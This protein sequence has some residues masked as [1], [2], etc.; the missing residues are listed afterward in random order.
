[1]DAPARHLCLVV[2]K[3]FVLDAL[4][5]ECTK[6]S[7]SALLFEYLQQVLGLPISTALGVYHL[8]HDLTQHVKVASVSSVAAVDMEAESK[9]CT[10]KCLFCHPWKTFLCGDVINEVRRAVLKKKGELP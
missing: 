6:G 3:Q 9:K 2:P 10:T 1:M 8:D 5:K 7:G 4:G